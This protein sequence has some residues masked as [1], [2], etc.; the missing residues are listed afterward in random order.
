MW[1]LQWVGDLMLECDLEVTSDSGTVL[2]DLV[3]GGRHFRCELDCGSGR[4]QLSIDGVSDFHPAAQSAVRG[5]GRYRVAFANIDEQLTLMLDGSP[6]EFD[7]QTS[8]KPLDN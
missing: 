8:Y 1:G 7:S 6:V 3:K 4:V 2:L 5:A